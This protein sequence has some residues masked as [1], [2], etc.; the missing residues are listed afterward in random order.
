V[1][2]DWLGYVRYGVCCGCLRLGLGLSYERLLLLSVV[3]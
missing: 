3:A 2:L 1:S